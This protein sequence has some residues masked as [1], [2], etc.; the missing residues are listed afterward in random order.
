MKLLAFVACEKVI[1]AKEDNNTSLITVLTELNGQYELAP[2]AERSKNDVFPFNWAIFAMWKFEPAEIGKTFIHMFKLRAPSGSDLRDHNRT[3]VE[4]VADKPVHR[5]VAKVPMVPIGESG[6]W[7]IDLFV[8]EKGTPL[9]TEP[10]ATY[11]I[12]IH[13]TEAKLSASASQVSSS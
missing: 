10:V 1:I 6:E 12:M 7:S 2:G 5:L 3:P 11:P 9:P 13:F 4:F 8:A